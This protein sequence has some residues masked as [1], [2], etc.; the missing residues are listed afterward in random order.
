MSDKCGA[1]LM[2]GRYTNLCKRNATSKGFCAQHAKLIDAL[3]CAL[4]GAFMAR[5]K[6]VDARVTCARCKSEWEA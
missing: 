3:K 2:R 6:G 5:P 4:C 1:V